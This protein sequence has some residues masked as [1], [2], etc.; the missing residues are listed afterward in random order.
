MKPTSRGVLLAVSL[1]AGVAVFT[2]AMRSQ[3][4]RQPTTWEYSAVTGFP[5]TDQMTGKAGVKDVWYSR[6]TICYAST[7]GCSYEEIGTTVNDSHQGWVAMMMAASKL[8]EEG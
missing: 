3:Q 6:A 8:G 2:T 1:F 7:S 4:I 5:V